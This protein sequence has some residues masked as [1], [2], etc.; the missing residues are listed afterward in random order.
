MQ[1]DNLVIREIIDSE[2]KYWMAMVD[3]DLE[4]ALSLTD[5]P[6]LVANA[7]GTQMVDK[8]EFEKTFNS[9]QAEMVS[10]FDF[11]ESKAEVRQVAPDTAVIAYKVQATVEKDGKS[12]TVEAID[13]STW[14][15]REAKW[16]CA[17]HT[18]TELLQ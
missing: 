15:R 18:E 11:D 16:V 9:R 7:Q 4:T 14:I 8:L 13:T 17:M 10:A 6:C 3:H 5:F 2:K 12:R 1:T